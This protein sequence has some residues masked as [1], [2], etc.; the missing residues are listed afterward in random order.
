[1][2]TNY[3]NLRVFRKF[4]KNAL[5][6]RF[7]IGDV[8]KCSKYM[9]LATD[10]SSDCAQLEARLLFYFHKIEK[11]LS[12]PP[13]RRLFGQT[14]VPVV[15]D[16]IKEWET[17]GCDPDSPVYRGA[18]SSLEAYSQRMKDLNIDLS[19]VLPEIKPFLAQRSSCTAPGGDTPLLLT[20]DEIKNATCLAE[21]EKLYRVRRSFRNYSDQ[22]VEFT[23][24]EKAIKLAQLSPSVCNRQSSKVYVVSDKQTISE[25]LAYQNGNKG[26]GHM[27]SHL[28]IVTSDLRS[29]ADAT[30]RN[31][32][33]VDGGLFS[34]SLVYALQAQGIVSC[35]L[36]WCLPAPRDKAFH[37]YSRIPDYE[38]I[39][40]FI[41]I[42]YPPREALVPKSHR[43]DLSSVCTQ[44]LPA[45]AK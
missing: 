22:T 31:Q 39:I 20:A 1:M 16:V 9:T 5:R 13:P 2:Q 12:M 21:L 18:I 36:N 40:M 27:A 17:G 38:R 14:V 23:A 44:G 6:L 45:A 28:L 41:V 10:R 29:F 34:M 32:P 43:R 11:G 37:K 35:C 42:G 25:A 30:E 3:K 8:W 33:F 4:L 7:Y 24:I 19:G 15:M 26:F